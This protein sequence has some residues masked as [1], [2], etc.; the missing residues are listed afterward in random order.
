MEHEHPRGEAGINVISPHVIPQPILIN[1]CIRTQRSR[2]RTCIFTER[3][4]IS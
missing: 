1:A 4:R 3:E 2:V